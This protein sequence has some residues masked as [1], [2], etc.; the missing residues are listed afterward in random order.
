[1]PVRD[2]NID[3][4]DIAIGG[5]NDAFL[6][7][8]MIRDAVLHILTRCAAQDRH[9]VVG[10]LPAEHAVV[11]RLLQCCLRKIAVLLL[12]FLQA[13][14][15]DRICSQPVQHMRQAHF[16]RIDVPGSQAHINESGRSG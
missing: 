5:C 16:Q 13:Q 11:A 12:G 9:A 1:M 4:P 2:I 8:A 7:V 14:H 10:L 3:Y 15:V 6:V